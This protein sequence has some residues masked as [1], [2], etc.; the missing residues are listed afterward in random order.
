MQRGGK[1]GVSFPTDGEIGVAEFVGH[2]VAIVWVSVPVQVFAWPEEPVEGDDGEVDEMGPAHAKLG[3][4]SV[5]DSE[6]S[7]EDGNVDRVCA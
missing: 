7:V 5:E 4:G 6:E 3:V 2:G 1:G